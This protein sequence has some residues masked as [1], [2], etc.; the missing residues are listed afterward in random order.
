MVTLTYGT[1]TVTLR[2]PVFG[3]SLKIETARVNQRTRGGDLILFRDPNWPVTKT[4]SYSFEALTQQ[5]AKDL[6]ALVEESLGDSIT[7]MDFEGVTRVG[8]ITTPVAEVI[9]TGRGCQFDVSFDFQ[10]I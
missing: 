2:D 1:R 4:T 5:Q 6:L 8:V 9:Q 10:E 7:M 3:N